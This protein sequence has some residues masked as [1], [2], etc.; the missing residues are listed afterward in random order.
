MF[1]IFGKKSIFKNKVISVDNLIESM[2]E[3]INSSINN[4]E[5]NWIEDYL[6][7]FDSFIENIDDIMYKMSNAKPNFYGNIVQDEIEKRFLKMRFLSEFEGWFKGI[8]E[9]PKIKKKQRNKNKNK[10]ELSSRI[11][12]L[13][14]TAER[15]DDKCLEKA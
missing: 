2:D 6:G 7:S 12:R 4:L 10:K 3:V 5:K 14:K 13:T 8:E 1:N 9:G 11:D 15:L